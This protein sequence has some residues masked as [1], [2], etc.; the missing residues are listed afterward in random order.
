[1]VFLR[2]VAAAA[3]VTGLAS[4]NA[5]AAPITLEG[6]GIVGQWTDL[7]TMSGEMP[8]H[9]WGTSDTDHAD[10]VGIFVQYADGLTGSATYSGL[11]NLWGGCCSIAGGGGLAPDTATGFF[12]G[13]TSNYAYLHGI[14]NQGFIL[15]MA[16]FDLRNTYTGNFDLSYENFGNSTF[17]ASTNGWRSV[18]ITL[19]SSA[20]AA[21]VP[22]PGSLALLAMGLAG[23]GYSRRKRAHR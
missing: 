22:E 6:M 23:L 1:M 21:A 10:G 5:Q 15:P 12:V 8:A 11:A 3:L 7:E 18:E 13:T 9:P 19:Y 16:F 2:L 14:D 20:A 4:G 17:R